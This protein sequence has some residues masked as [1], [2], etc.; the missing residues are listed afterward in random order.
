MAEPLTLPGFVNAHSHAFQRSLRGRSEG[1]DFWAWRESMLE[2]ASGLTPGQ[3]DTGRWIQAVVG[4]HESLR[5]D[6]P[7]GVPSPSTSAR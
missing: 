2:V 5:G 4:V 6:P 7:R 1:D 3:V